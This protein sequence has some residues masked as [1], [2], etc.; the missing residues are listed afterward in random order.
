M[1]TS[2][3]DELIGRQLGNFVIERLLGVGGMAH[4]YQARDVLLERE[5]A[6]K[7]LSPMFLTDPGY[8][9]RFRSEAHHVAALE[10]QHIVPILQFIEQDRGLYVVMPLYA[11]SLRDILDVK[12]RLPLDEALRI[13][14]EIGPALA[15]AHSQGLVHRDVKPGNIL[16][17]ANGKAALTDFGIA[18]QATF[19]GNPDALTLAGTG[20]PIGTPQYMP[21]EQLRGTG[22]D[23]R[24]DIYALSV[25]LYEMLTGRTPHVGNTPFEVAAA[26]LTEPVMRPSQL[27]PEIPAAVEAVILRALSKRAEDRYANV[28]SFVED[29]QKA[30][31]KPAPGAASPWPTLAWPSSH[32]T[33]RLRLTGP[34]IQRGR[35]WWMT[36]ALITLAVIIVLGGG[37]VLLANLMAAPRIHVPTPGSNHGGLTTVATASPQA[38]ETVGATTTPGTTPGS[39]PSPGATATTPPPPLLSLG[40]LHLTRHGGQCTGSQTITNSGGQ[41]MT[42]RWESVNPSVPS[43]F[44][45]SVG[46]NAPAQTGGLPGDQ[47][48][49]PTGP[50]GTDTLNVQMKCTAQNYT[51]TLRDGLGR[52]Q[53]FTMTSE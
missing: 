52:T 25:V 13:V 51:V 46:V 34:Q 42:W 28:Q 41:Q 14:M 33:G 40:A 36:L 48:P 10:H 44:L 32:G 8:V 23:Y 47:N 7:A 16:L 12:K 49:I 53:T 31:Q 11:E 35:A 27:N 15:L 37:V 1:E 20:L 43:S 2:L 29:L 19:Q 30:A 9:E 5:V 17:D 38:T 4:V 39:T 22:V 26:A 21:P 3:R 50:G 24:S 45:Y 18:R 6:I